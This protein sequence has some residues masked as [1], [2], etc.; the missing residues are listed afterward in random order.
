MK[1][2]TLRPLVLLRKVSRCR[3]LWSI[4]GMILT[5]EYRSGRSKTCRNES[6]STTNPNTHCSGGSKIP[7]GDKQED[8]LLS[9]DAEFYR[10]TLICATLRSSVLT[11]K[12]KRYLPL[13]RTSRWRLRGGGGYL[14]PPLRVVWNINVRCDQCSITW[15]FFWWNTQL[16][17]DFDQSI[18]CYSWYDSPRH[19][20]YNLLTSLPSIRQ[21]L[22]LF[23]SV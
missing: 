22:I 3:W 7:C 17:L 20:Y 19:T 12:W 1:V 18:L 8:N 23:P 16:P 21:F 9:H 10:L 11:W 14:F 5:Q 15:C 13:T 6:W 4:G 2:S